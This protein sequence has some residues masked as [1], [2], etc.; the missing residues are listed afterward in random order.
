MSEKTW[1]AYCV[2]NIDTKEHEYFILSRPIKLSARHSA[3]ASALVRKG[4]RE[5]YWEQSGTFAVRADAR[6]ARD[7]MIKNWTLS[8]WHP[9][10]QEPEEYDLNL[11]NINAHN[12]ISCPFIMREEFVSAAIERRKINSSAQ[13]KCRINKDPNKPKGPPRKT[14]KEKELTKINRNNTLRQ[15]RLE[16]KESKLITYNIKNVYKNRAQDLTDEEF[17]EI[18]KKD[19]TD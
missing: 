5:F 17:D 7:Q 9:E 11:Q 2:T 10:E 1:T 6:G 14:D 15:R 4:W 13:T 8:Y 16:I 12:I 19:D 18:Y 3:F